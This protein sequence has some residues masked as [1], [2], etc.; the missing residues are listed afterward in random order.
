MTRTTARTTTK[1]TT[2]ATIETTAEVRAGTKPEGPD[3]AGKSLPEHVAR[4][5]VGFGALIGSVVLLPLVGP[6]G[7]ALLP[8]GLFALRGCPMCWA[9][10]LMQTVSRGRLQRSC[11][12]G[13]CRLTI[14][15]HD[16]QPGAAAS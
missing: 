6:A 11:E 10:G 12:D 7:L 3:Y 9:I 16:E 14:A 2:R 5:V 15:G 8:I 1:A 13:Q 4:G